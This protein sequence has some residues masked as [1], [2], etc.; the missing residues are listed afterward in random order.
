MAA[1]CGTPRFNE[2]DDRDEMDAMLEVLAQ[3]I[4]DE[5]VSADGRERAAS[6]VGRRIYDAL[7]RAERAERNQ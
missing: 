6:K 5:L 3:Y 1:R 4:A 2:I 7:E